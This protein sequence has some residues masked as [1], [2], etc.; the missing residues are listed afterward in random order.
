MKFPRTFDKNA[1]SLVKHLLQADLSKRY[2]NL[3]GGVGDIKQH[4]FYKDFDWMKLS[5]GKLKAPY[6][7]DIKADNDASHFNQYPDSDTLPKAL[8]SNEDPFLEW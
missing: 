1:K 4:R 7:P 6:I 3:K 8:K 5:E 2:G